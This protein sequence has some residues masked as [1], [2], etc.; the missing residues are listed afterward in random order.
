[1]KQRVISEGARRIRAGYSPS[2]EKEEGRDEGGAAELGRRLSA[3]VR[4][5][6]SNH[7]THLKDREVHSNDKTTNQHTQNSHDH[8]LH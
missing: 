5:H 3:K 6:R 8:R 4:A 1:M 2:L 7:L